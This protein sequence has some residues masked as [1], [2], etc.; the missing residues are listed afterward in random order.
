MILRPKPG[1]E[2]VP[3][4]FYWL[5]EP[6]AEWRMCEV[7]STGDLF[8]PAGENLA[9][10]E[11]KH[12]DHVLVPVEP[13]DSFGFISAKTADQVLADTEEQVENAKKLVELEPLR[14]LSD[15]MKDRLR[16]GVEEPSDEEGEQF[17]PP[18]DDPD[19][20]A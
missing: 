19:T 17:T 3:S 15:T 8:C 6:G 5:G 12:L 13:P 2:P 4:G 16:T 7:D 1:D 9:I 20:G 10:Y 14:D 11:P 18:P